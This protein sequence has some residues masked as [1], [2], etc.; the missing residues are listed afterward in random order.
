[1]ATTTRTRIL[2]LDIIRGVAVMGILAMNIYAFAGPGAMYFNPAAYGGDSGIDWLVWAFNFVLVD[3][4]MR[5]LFSILFGASTLLVIERA[6][7]KSDRP[8]VR[9]YARM[10]WL[11]AFG[12]VHF[13]FIW[14]GDILA[15]YAIAGL[16]LF[17]WRNCS[18]KVLRI[19]AIV[20]LTLGFLFVGSQNLAFRMADNPD[21]TAEQRKSLDQALTQTEGFFGANTPESEAKVREHLE[22]HRGSYEEIVDKRFVEWRFKPFTNA[23]F[24]LPETLGLMLVGMALFKSG[25]LTGEWPRERYRKWAITLFAIGVPANL[26]LLVW[27]VQSDYDAIVVLNSTLVL[28][29]PFDVLMAIGWAAL[30]TWLAKGAL[31]GPLAT[32]IGAAG[33]MAFTNYLMTSIVMTTIFYG[34]G[35]GLYGEVGRAGLYLFVIGMWALML[36]WSKPWLD[37]FRYGPFEWLWRSLSRFSLQ[38]MGRASAAA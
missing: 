19:W 1:M 35:L 38:P 2:T 25:F 17:F 30:V 24:L 33:R 13:W 34:Y 28:S 10:I 12:L 11:L 3:S 32:R 8:A 26:A 27:Q 5:G 20:M 31:E 4:K 22:L 14:W 9:H 36:L 6:M 16:F 23:L 15:I 7:A 37:R 21:L 29:M 18:V